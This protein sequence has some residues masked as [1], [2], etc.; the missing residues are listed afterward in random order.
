VEK[1]QAYQE[2]HQKEHQK[3]EDQLIKK[4][5]EA[6]TSGKHKQQILSSSWLNSSGCPEKKG[7][8]Q[9]SV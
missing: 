1:G 2:Q 3:D 7:K 5:H 8:K 6:M 9:F 4:I